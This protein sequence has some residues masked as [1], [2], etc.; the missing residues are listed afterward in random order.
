MWNLKNAGRY[1]DRRHSLTLIAM[2]N[3]TRCLMYGSACYIR[4]ERAPRARAVVRD[5]PRRKRHGPRHDSFGSRCWGPRRRA[6]AVLLVVLASS[7][8]ATLAA[9]KGDTIGGATLSGVVHDSATGLPPIRTWVCA[10]ELRSEAGG[11]AP[12]VEVDSAGTYRIAD[13]P[14]GRFDVAALC[15]IANGG[16]KR[17]ASAG[18]SIAGSESARHDWMVS[19]AGCDKRPLRQISGV[20]R[21]HYYAGF[22]ASAFVPCPGEGWFLPSDTVGVSILGS[23]SAWVVGVGRA[24]GSAKWPNVEGE[25]AANS[26]YYVQWKGTVVG[27]GHYGHLGGSPFLFRVDSIL[28]VRAVSENDCR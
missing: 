21:G 25:E 18:V 13:L 8:A 12:C 22:E 19:T 28:E 15:A 7:P 10:R 20:Y 11:A 1:T 27:P 2:R 9:Q 24:R 6:G 14:A 4:P 5:W 16:R 23:H 17:I 26:S 3:P